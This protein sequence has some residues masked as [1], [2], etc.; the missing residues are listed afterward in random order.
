MKELLSYSPRSL[1]FTS[2]TLQPMESYEDIFRVKF[3]S[4]FSCGHVIDTEKQLKVCAVRK[5]GMTKIMKF[6]YK[7]RDDG[8]LKKQLGHFILQLVKATP[9]GMVVFF[10]SYAAMSNFY[11]C[12]LDLGIINQMEQ[13]KVICREHK[14]A[15]Q[16]KSSFKKFMRYY[17]SKG[18]LFMGVCSGKLS[19][20]IDFTDEMARMVIMVGVPFPSTTSPAVNSKKIYMNQRVNEDRKE[21]K[22][23]SQQAKHSNGNGFFGNNSVSTLNLIFIRKRLA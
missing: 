1:I 15:R 3:E 5:L 7:A 10:S 4:R 19:E 21:K 12:W 13:I 18:A 11:E 17:K 14:Y 23:L 16:F 2:G 9:K 22:R 8:T 6:D 20:G